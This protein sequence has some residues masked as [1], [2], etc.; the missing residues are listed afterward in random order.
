[1]LEYLLVMIAILFALLYAVRAGGPI[2]TAAEKVMNDSASTMGGAVNAAR[3]R[4]GF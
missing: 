3:A 4:M 2:Q 1:M